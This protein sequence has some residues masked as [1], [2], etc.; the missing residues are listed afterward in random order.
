MFNVARAVDRIIKVRASFCVPKCTFK[1]RV[2]TLV[3]ELARLEPSIPGHER[4]IID[5]SITPTRVI[6]T[7]LRHVSKGSWQPVLY[8]VK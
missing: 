2:F 8:I 7:E 1:M 5:S 6:M 3:Q 4:W